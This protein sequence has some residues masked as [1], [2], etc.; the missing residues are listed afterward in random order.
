MMKGYTIIDAN[1]S[2]LIQN[3]TIASEDV[4]H[5]EILNLDT[6]MIETQQINV[7]VFGK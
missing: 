6:G 5:C 4:Y 2:L 1:F 3:V 7:T